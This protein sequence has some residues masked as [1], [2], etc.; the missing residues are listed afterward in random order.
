VVGVASAALAGDT[1]AA[2]DRPRVP[3]EARTT[4]E[5]APKDMVK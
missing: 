2:S 3:R 1:A 4:R 5:R